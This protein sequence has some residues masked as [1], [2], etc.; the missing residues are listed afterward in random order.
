MSG[1]CP[2]VLG[3][4]PV[5]ME[6]VWGGR[7]LERYGKRLEA[8]KSYGES[9]ELCDLAAT[10]AS[11]GG[12]GAA[13]SVIDRGPWAGRTIGEAVA[14]WGADLVG[15]GVWSRIGGDATPA[16]P[17]L[18]KFLDAR[19]HLSVQV[20]PSP[21]FAAAHDW[22]HLKTESWL[23]V[24]AEEAELPKG[25][26][27]P[28]SVFKGIEPGV[29]AEGFAASI[30]AGEVVG[31]LTRHAAVPGECHTLPSG[32]CHALGGGVLVLE[33][34]TPSDTTFRVY[35][36]AAEYGRSGRELHVDD[37]KACLSFDEGGGQ[38]TPAAERGPEAA[39][40]AVVAETEW[41]R[42]RSVRT[43]GPV[44]IEGGL[45]RVVV[46][47]SGAGRVEAGASGS[48]ALEAGRTLLVP[49]CAPGFEVVGEGGSVSA[50]V[51][52]VL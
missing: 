52:D 43:E 31:H 51:V 7:R 9:W 16:F 32:T 46:G 4:E 20:H 8:G 15:A 21:A 22:A 47:L 24:E 26:T 19:E 25:V 40:A 42:M 36:W 27:E 17:L 30:P 12:G 1:D 2:Y 35:D 37:A 18:I 6:K 39:G 33:V 44:R 11:G 49:A 48:A 28:P 50:C 10:A 38:S 34:Q 29:D 14:A 23:V 5:L 3:F 45:C 13:R 41:Y